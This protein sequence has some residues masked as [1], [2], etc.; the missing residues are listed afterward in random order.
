MIDKGCANRSM[1]SAV[2]GN[3]WADL[4]RPA[5]PHGTSHEAVHDLCPFE[6]QRPLRFHGLISHTH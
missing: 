3:L 5:R 4:A 6:P 2:G 1:P